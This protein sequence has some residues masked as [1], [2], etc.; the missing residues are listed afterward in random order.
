MGGNVTVILPERIKR[1]SESSSNAS[2]LG[3]MH[4]ILKETFSCSSETAVR[5]TLSSIMFS[6]SW[7]RNQE[8][9]GTKETFY[10]T[11]PYPKEQL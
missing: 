8:I 10:P 1:M 6:Y 11:G 4:R 2:A 9:H 3:Q 5:G 7:E